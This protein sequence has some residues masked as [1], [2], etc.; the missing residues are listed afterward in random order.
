MKSILFLGS[1]PKN[2]KITCD[3]KAISRKGSKDKKL[4][5]SPTKNGF[6]EGHYEENSIFA[7]H[8]NTKHDR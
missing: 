4:V 5:P 3:S 8:L 2:R 6:Q 1:I 7:L